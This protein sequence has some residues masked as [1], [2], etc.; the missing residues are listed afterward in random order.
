[1]TFLEEMQFELNEAI[2]IELG[3]LPL[4]GF[5]GLFLVESFSYKIIIILK[6]LCT[7]L[8]FITLI[9][10][11]SVV[12]ILSFDFELTNFVLGEYLISLSKLLNIYNI[13]RL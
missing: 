8:T 7:L 1:M 10:F 2:F 6:A 4:G 12:D 9:D 13:P 3:F 5:T 11:L